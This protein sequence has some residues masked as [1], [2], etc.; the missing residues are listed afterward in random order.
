MKLFQRTRRPIWTYATVV[1]LLSI[2]AYYLIMRNVWLADI[3]Q[4]LE[5]VKQKVERGIHAQHLSGTALSDAIDH[6]NAIDAGV[7]LSMLP[8]DS[9]RTDRFHTRVKFDALHGHD[10]PFR[11]YESTVRLNG[12]PY[13]ITVSRVV[14]ETEELVT[15]I[16]LVALVSLVLLFGGMLVL[17]RV[18]AGRIW[19]PFQHLLARLKRFQVDGTAHFQAAKTG[20]TEFDELE[21]E[22]E[23]LTRRN[24]AIY[25]EQRRFTENAAHELRTPIALLQGKVERLFQSEGLTRP[26]AEL[27]EEANSGIRRMR[28]TLDGL[29]TLTYVDNAPLHADAVCDPEAIIRALLDQAKER[30]S[31]LGLSLELHVAPDVRWPMEPAMAEILLGNLVSNA[32][33]HNV[34]NGTMCIALSAEKFSFS[35]T[36]ADNALDTER[37]FKRFSAPAKGLGLGLAIAQR[38]CERQGWQL[39]YSFLVGMHTFEARIPNAA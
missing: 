29:L 37:L 2:P 28:L 17:D 21:R 26:Q 20:V 11:I 25:A 12:V 30:I 13:A 5:V 14:E 27:L 39:R 4:D 38:V 19:A 36:G 32:V 16:A 10:E 24:M 8:A 15:S 33:R 3:D 7:Q 34:R 22:L 35:N 9:T 23:Q 18:Y 1:M 31:N 6:I